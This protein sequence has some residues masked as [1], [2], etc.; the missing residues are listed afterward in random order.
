MPSIPKRWQVAPPVSPLVIAR[1]SELH[2]VLVQILYNRGITTPEQS[3]SFLAPDTLIGN[4]FQLRGMN[5]TVERLRNAM[6]V[7]EKIAVYGDFD[8]DGVTATALLVQTLRALGAN[9]MPYIP[10]RID[11]GYGLN[12][13]ALKQLKDSETRVVVTVDCGIRSLDEVA[14]GTSLGLDMIVTDHHSPTDD[15]PN[16]FAVINPKQTLCAYPYKELSGSGIAFKVAQG[17]LRAQANVP[18]A[19]IADPA[20]PSGNGAPIKEED[21]VDLV[22]LGTVADLVPLT[23]ENRALVKDG[24]AQLRKTERPGIQAMLRY[25]SL[26]MDTIDAATIGYTL[27]PRLNAAGRLEHA[28]QA[29]DLLTTQYPDEADSLAQKLEN[30]NRERQRLTMEL[31]TKAQQIVAPTAENDHLLFVTAPEFPE[32]IVGLIASRLSEEYYRPAIAVH[33]GPTESRGSAR[34]ISEFNIVAALD[35]CRDLLVRHGGHSMAAGFTVRNENLSALE[36]RLKTIAARA[37]SGNEIAPTL[38]VDAETT[39]AQM[40]W[41]LQKALVSLEPFGYGNREP[42]F[43][44]RRVLVRDSR[45]VGNGH[46]KLLLSDGQVVWDA[47]AFRHGEWAPKVP[48]QIDLVYQLDARVWNGEARLQLNVRDLR[49]ADA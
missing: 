41:S 25:A 16:A 13:E 27:G 30:T 6:R 37:L 38:F 49:P 22:A 48:R 36:S 39:L 32:G 24:L 44:S 8:V 4:P 46:L 43:L 26:K 31:T 14:F 47:I 12:R 34:S 42:L 19:K 1:F 9:A 28:L 45:V 21:L 11:E 2:P 3:A 29:Y 10:H 5:E 18:L 35:E 20:I 15:L 7:G 23:G 40:D 17:L 33:R